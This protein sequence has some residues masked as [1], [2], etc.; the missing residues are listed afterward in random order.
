MEKKNMKLIK[1]KMDSWIIL[2]NIYK[3]KLILIIV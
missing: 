2:R 3:I 1:Y